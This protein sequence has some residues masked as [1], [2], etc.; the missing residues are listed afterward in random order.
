MRPF[1]CYGTMVPI[2]S[3]QVRSPIPSSLNC[4]RPIRSTRGSVAG[5]AALKG[6]PEH[7][8]DLAADPLISGFQRRI[9]N[10]VRT[11]LSVPLKREGV[12]VGLI[13]V[14]HN[15]V[16][17]FTQRQIGL[18]STFADQAVIAINNVGLFEEVQ[19]RNRDLTALREVG[20]TVS[21][22][23]DLKVAL[24]SMVDRAVELSTTDGGSI[25]YY[26]P[27]IGRFELS[28]TAGLEEEVV[29]RFRMLDMLTGQTGM[30]EAIAKRRPGGDAATHDAL[31]RRRVAEAI[32]DRSVQRALA[33]VA[34]ARA[35]PR[36]SSY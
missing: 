33:S 34:V 26:R 5:R 15:R 17:P 29:A 2:T 25:F 22:T 11:A 18:V 24:K 4:C 14:W 10:K 16:P 13:S 32:R 36:T 35:R 21:S 3:P 28:E 12:V 31:P 19:A 30:G 6:L 9:S 27:E 20:R 1:A 7:V 8:P 23:L